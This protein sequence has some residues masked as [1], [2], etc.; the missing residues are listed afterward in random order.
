MRDGLIWSA[1]LLPNWHFLFFGFPLVVTQSQLTV[2][3]CLSSYIPFHC[4]AFFIFI[5]CLLVFRCC[6]HRIRGLRVRC[7]C[8]AQCL[9]CIGGA[10]MYDAIPMVYSHFTTFHAPSTILMAMADNAITHGPNEKSGKWWTLSFCF[11]IVFCRRWNGMMWPWSEW[12][13]NL[14]PRHQFVWFSGVMSTWFVSL[15]LI[16]S[17]Q[18][19]VYRIR[20]GNICFRRGIN[21]FKYVINIRPNTS[22]SRLPFYFIF[23]FD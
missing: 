13:N 18:F 19:H 11:F 23:F 2:A 9:P 10:A 22:R 6:Y 17:F 14:W 15:V 20:G 1:H 8:A 5:V 3:S 7:W 21:R 12:R 4:F 16:L